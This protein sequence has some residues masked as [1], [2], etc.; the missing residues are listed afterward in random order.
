MREGGRQREERTEPEREL[1]R[2]RWRRRNREK[3]GREAE[4][5]AV[6]RPEWGDLG[7]V[8]RIRKLGLTCIHYHVL[9]R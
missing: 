7:K 6:L 2:E 3:G 4:G 5:S 8:G 9:N 1:E